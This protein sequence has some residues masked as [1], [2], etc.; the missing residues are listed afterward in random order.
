MCA[1]IKPVSSF[2]CHQTQRI[3][4]F[5]LSSNHYD[6][7]WQKTGIFPNY[8][9]ILT[10]PK[11]TYLVAAVLIIKVTSPLT[12]SLRVLIKDNL[13]WLQQTIDYLTIII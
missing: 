7:H 13:L 5:K 3:S 11:D 10:T 8:N 2:I 6:N 1:R 9:V 12:S 4:K